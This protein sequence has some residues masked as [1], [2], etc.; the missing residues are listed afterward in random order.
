MHPIR[1]RLLSEEIS[2]L[3]ENNR[4]HQ[5]KLQT[6]NVF[7]NYVVRRKNLKDKHWNKIRFS[8]LSIDDGNT[9]LKILQIYLV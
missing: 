8:R 6:E 2:K 5:A 4:F 1:R 7:G 9:V 3:Q